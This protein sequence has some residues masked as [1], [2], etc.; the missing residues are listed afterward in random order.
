MGKGGGQCPPKCHDPPPPPHVMD[1]K[2]P[3]VKK[4]NYQNKTQ[5]PKQKKCKDGQTCGEMTDRQIEK[6]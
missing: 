2:N 3:Q 4:K 1:H 6:N 5:E